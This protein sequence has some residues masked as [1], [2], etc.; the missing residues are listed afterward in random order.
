MLADPRTCETAHTIGSGRE[1][2]VYV[3][4]PTGEKMSKTTLVVLVSWLEM[5]I[6]YK[7]LFPNHLQTSLTHFYTDP[8][9]SVEI[10]IRPW[11]LLG[12]DIFDLSTKCTLYAGTQQALG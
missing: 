12:A 9:P 11:T 10:L 8:N 3:R 6:V 4:P 1:P 7:A 2:I 5:K